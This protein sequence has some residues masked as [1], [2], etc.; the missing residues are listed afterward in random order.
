MGLR[1]RQKEAIDPSR[2]VCVVAGAGTGKTHI[3]ISKY[4]DLLERG[5]NSSDI[6]A[7]TFT[8]KAASEMK[9]RIEAALDLQVSEYPSRWRHIR[10]E[11][12]W[13]DISTFHSFC[14]KVLHEFPIEANIAPEF[15]IIDELQAK[16]LQEEALEV[17][18]HSPSG[19]S[20]ESICRL[21][22][23]TDEWHVKAYLRELYKNRI[24]VE[25]FFKE[26]EGDDEAII[27]RWKSQ[28]RDLQKEI[29]SVFQSNNELWGTIAELHRLASACRK[30]KDGAMK[31]LRSIESH[32]VDLMEQRSP[33]IALSAM[34]ELSGIRGRTNMGSSA[35][36][37]P[38]DLKSLRDSYGRLQSFFVANGPLLE[39]R[40]GDENFSKYALGF[41][42]D[43]KN[44]F[45][46]YRKN[47]DELKRQSGGIDFN[48]M[49]FAAYRLF[50]DHKDL[51]RAHFLNRYSYI[52]IDE[53]QD[54]DPIQC[55]I[56]WTI[57]GNLR[58]KSDRLFVVGD[59]KQSIYLFRDADVTLFKEMQEIIQDGLKG[60]IVP[61]NIN[62][63]ST[64]Q[65]VYFVNYLFSKI[66][67][68]SSK[69]WEFGYEPLD[70]SH[71]RIN[72][73]GSVELLLAPSTMDGQERSNSEAEMIARRIQNLIETENKKIYW[74]ECKRKLSS[75]RPAQY[76]DVAILLQRRTNL[77][78]LE[79]ALQKYGI[80]YHVSSGLGFYERQEIVDLFNLLK[81]LDNI[82]D[83]VALYGILRSPYF[84]ISDVQLHKIAKSGSGSLWSRVQQCS[85]Q[86]ESSAVSNA[87]R[88]LEDWSSRAH[89]EPIAD[90][91]RVIIESS[92]IYAVYGGLVDG[93]RIIANLEKFL[94]IA[95]DAQMHGITLISDFAA[96]LELL[97]DEA[98]MEGEGQIDSE[99]ANVV[100]IMT[101]HASKGLEFPI[102]VIPDMAGKG[103]KDRPP[104]MVDEIL[105]IGLRVPDP[106]N[107][108]KLRDTFQ[109]QLLKMR[110]DEKSE[111]ERKRLFYVAVTRAKDHL[112]LCGSIIEE[113]ES[114]EEGATWLDWTYACLGING[115][116]IQD[117][118]VTFEWPKGSSTIISIP[119]ID[120][121]EDIPA[122]IRERKPELLE[123]P[124]QDLSK[125]EMPEF[126]R[127]VQL[128]EPEHIF[129]A[130]EVEEYKLCP[131]KYNSK[132]VIGDPDRDIILPATGENARIQGLIIHEIFQGKD[133]SMVFR[134]YSIS[135]SNKEGLYRECYDNFLSSDF[136]KDVKEDHRELPFLA[137]IDGILFS[138]KIDR[139]TKKGDGSWNIIDYK[140]MDVS[141]E[142]MVVKSKEYSDQFAIYRNVMQQ[143][144]GGEI[145]IFT[146]FTS[147]ERFFPVKLDDTRVISNI[148]KIVQKN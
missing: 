128:P 105:G 8:R 88:L 146:Y 10:D 25:E 113:I 136:M 4:I 40:E 48:D 2:S 84:G 122:E 15:I 78:Y 139:I 59:P 75:P 99:N 39:I 49:I 16:R 7:L 43:L 30:D 61:L 50:R 114:L 22:G 19:I 119:I 106:S 129:S 45:K 64:P 54:T 110:R 9:E 76:S 29:L 26:L 140:T 86:H 94:Q 141:E 14:S 143:L 101:V 81:F 67:S 147:I 72:D 132:Y 35:N 1:G 145:C 79:R 55:K 87:V 47:V 31:Y 133:P 135:D 127:P 77:R 53:F 17:C 120:D 63:R 96:E 134:K 18:L 130:S 91:L 32:L 69:P 82:L 11:F 71:E 93:S 73:S 52:L 123:A 58:E 6:L 115:K 13:A 95:R 104:L 103:E 70:V 80:P 46:E 98:P 23:D 28:F 124:E 116:N 44:V 21:L 118:A 92:G 107:E 62:F 100:K 117:G 90:L 38:E 33:E 20:R 60:K 36:W 137:R 24:F 42:R 121:P 12:I 41:L 65:I 142:Q 37:K 51:V 83:D 112:I 57:L 111:A 74:D 131:K 56:I 138:G 108:Y 125:A 5:Y 109:L 97:I 148:K 126:L 144:L 3:L 66:L 102:V 27:E 89:V 85:Q 68:S 34:T